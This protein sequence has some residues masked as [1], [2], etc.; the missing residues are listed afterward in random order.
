M[1]R[2][3]ILAERERLRERIGGVTFALGLFA[4]L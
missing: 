3:Q 4:F 2:G 1:P